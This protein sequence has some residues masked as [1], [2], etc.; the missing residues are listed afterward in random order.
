M[1]WVPMSTR[2]SL[3]LPPSLPPSLQ[4]RMVGPQ[5]VFTIS[6]VDSL[7]TKLNR[8]Q[9]ELGIPPSGRVPLS[10]KAKPGVM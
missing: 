8:A 3:P 4:A 5:Y 9:D 1:W 10:Y 6:S 7:E 2:P